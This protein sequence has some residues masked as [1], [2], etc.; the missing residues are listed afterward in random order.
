MKLSEKT[1]RRTADGARRSAR[2]WLKC[3]G[4]T[5][6]TA[7]AG[8]VGALKTDSHSSC[9]SADHSACGGVTWKNDGA[10]VSHG[11]AGAIIAMAQRRESGD[12]STTHSPSL[13]G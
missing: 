10:S 3:P 12:R 7:I 2:A 1:V 9:C 13:Y 8:S 11:A 6:C 4:A 5:S